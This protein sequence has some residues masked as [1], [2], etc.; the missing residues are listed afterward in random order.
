M[1]RLRQVVIA[2]RDLDAT[3]ADLTAV[4]GIRVGFNDPGVAEF[5][6]VNAVMPVGDTFLEVVSP[7]SASAPA[8]RFIDRRGGDGGYM[9]MIQSSD[10]DADR[11]RAADLGVRVAWQIDLDDIRGTHLHPADVG[12]AIL[13]IDQPEPA[14]SWRWGGPK[15]KDAVRT[16]VTR[17]V[18]GVEF[19]S[20]DPERLAAQWGRVLARPVERTGDALGIALDRGRLTFRRGA[21]KG[22]DRV[23][24]YDVAGD[25]KRVLATAKERGLPTTGD[26]VTIAGT[27]FRVEAA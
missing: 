14:P 9:V 24:T 25:A 2:A 4:L 22:P 8:R 21:E 10:L 3:V 27:G 13:S 12:A 16:D 18:T 23:V 26:C 5:G 17:A 19:A 15:W 20:D 11:K 7:V 6:L 1:M